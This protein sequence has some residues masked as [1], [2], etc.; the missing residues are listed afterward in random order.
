MTARPA[1]RATW[2]LLALSLAAAVLRR[3]SRPPIG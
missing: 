2:Y 3:R 1:L